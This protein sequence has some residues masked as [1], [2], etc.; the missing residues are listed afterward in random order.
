M[1]IASLVDRMWP[2]GRTRKSLRLDSQAPE[3][4]P[5]V[6][7]RKWFSADINHW[8]QF[9]AC[10]ERELKD[11]AMQVRKKKLL[12]SA[13]G[14]QITL[15]FGAKDQTKRTHVGRAI[16][17]PNTAFAYLVEPASARAREGER[18][19]DRTGGT[20]TRGELKRKMRM[21]R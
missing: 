19:T 17:D 7:L 5:S 11:E 12:A 10:Y 14:R 8:I 2:R 16:I 4:V 1:V 20:G 21:Y 15:V 18:F 6:A 9:Q 13:D 3:L